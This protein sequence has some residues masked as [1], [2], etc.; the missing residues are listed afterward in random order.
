MGR[1]ECPEA[2]EAQQGNAMRV[3]STKA[4]G[5]KANGKK[6]TSAPATLAN[7]GEA[8][9]DDSSGDDMSTDSEFEA[10]ID[11]NRCGIGRGWYINCKSESPETLVWAK[12]LVTSVY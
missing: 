12:R 10:E 3:N 9:L 2:V 4:N 6:A 5:T 8:H 11:G 1:D 7:M